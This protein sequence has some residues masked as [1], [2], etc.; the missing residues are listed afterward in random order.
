M[1][2]SFRSDFYLLR[3]YLRTLLGVF[4]IMMVFAFIQK[5]VYFAYFYPVFMAIFLP[6]SMFAL[7]EQSGWEAMLLSAPVSRRGIVR[8]RY[9]ACTVFSCSLSLIGFVCSLI[10]DP[11]ELGSSVFS[12]LVALIIILLCNAILLPVI[13]RFGPNKARFVIMAICIVPALLLPLVMD[14]IES[15]G[16]QFINTLVTLFSS[17][18]FM[19]VLLACSIAVFVLSYLISC[20]IYS[21]KEF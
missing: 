1:L 13:Y 10:I 5:S 7:S 6:I 2:A 21:K 17:T 12:L 11:K 8:G 9:L 16:L 18:W 4:A 20:L 19:L 15:N 14:T 3:G